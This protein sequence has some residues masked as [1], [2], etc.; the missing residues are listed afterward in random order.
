MDRFQI[1]MAQRALSVTPFMVME[2]MD[3]A[4]RLE[5]AGRNVIHMEV[6]EPDFRT[7]RVIVEAME[8]ALTTGAFKYGHSQGDPELRESLSWHYKERY[9]V[10]ID[11]DRFLICPGTSPGLLLLFGALLEAGDAVLMSDP[12][13]CCYPNLV[14]FFGGRVVF[15]PV[16][17]SEGFRLNPDEVKKKLNSS[18][19]AILINSPANPTG[20][21]LGPD[22]LKGLANLDRLIISDEIYHGLSYL[23]ERDHTILEYTDQAVV[24][25]GFSKAF[26]MTGW[27]VGYLIL[28]PDMVRSLLSM[29]QNFVI[30]TNAAAQKA[31]S[32]ALRQAWPEVLKMRSVYDRRRKVLIEGLRALGLGLMSDPAGAFYVL[33]RADHLNPDSK[34]LVFEILNEVAVGL[35]PGIEFGSGA[36]G[37][38][39][40]SYATSEANILEGLNRLS[41]FISAR[42][43][44]VAATKGA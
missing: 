40:F 11:P 34:S 20:A 39:R 23:D 6:G 8:K 18:I 16:N 10:D 41:D 38:L 15:S 5:R 4:Q 28:P 35:T 32:V 43:P 21:V 33:A 17:E 3:A 37:F 9:G 2:V 13:Y 12:A 36:E 1:H 22:Y 26:A 24:V 27:R 25:G 7:P 42:D 19:K 31:A 44:K 29:S 30:S 14:K